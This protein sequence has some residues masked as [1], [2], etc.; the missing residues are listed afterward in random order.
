[1]GAIKRV[2][3]PNTGVAQ[4]EVNDVFGE[5]EHEQVGVELVR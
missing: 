5:R 3:V 4:N 1:M 2:F